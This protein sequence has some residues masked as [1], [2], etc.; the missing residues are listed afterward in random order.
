MQETFWT[1][2]ELSASQEGIT[3]LFTQLLGRKA[4]S[5]L[6][7]HIPEDHSILNTS[8]RLHKAEVLYATFPKTQLILSN[9]G[10]SAAQMK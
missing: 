4:C 6:Q 7:C 10:P 8:I 5:E 2:S 3:H 9:A 1:S